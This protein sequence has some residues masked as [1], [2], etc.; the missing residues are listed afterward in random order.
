[1]DSPINFRI[2]L[3]LQLI[4]PLVMLAGLPFVPGMLTPL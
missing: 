1:M 3:I 2:P 4:F